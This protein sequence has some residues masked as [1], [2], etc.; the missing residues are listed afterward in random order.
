VPTFLLQPLVAALADG[1]HACVH[2]RAWSAGGELRLRIEAPDGG[3]APDTAA[4]DALAG[5]L[6]RPHGSATTL[7]LARVAGMRVL[8][9]RLPHRAAAEYTPALTEAAGG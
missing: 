2:V 5:R 4:L 8:D 6:R 3:P 7:A 1:A 9:V